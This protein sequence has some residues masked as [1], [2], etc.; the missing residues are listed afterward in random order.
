MMRKHDEPPMPGIEWCEGCDTPGFYREVTYGSTC[1][2][3]AVR[4]IGRELLSAST[5]Y[6][7]DYP[8]AI[9]GYVHEGFAEMRW[10]DKTWELAP[11]TA[12]W[13]R[14]RQEG[15]RVRMPGFVPVHDIVM[16]Y[17]AGSADLFA[18]I[19]SPAGAVRLKRPHLVTS[20]FAEM[21]NEIRYGTSWLEHNAL[22]L[23]RL[24]A[25]RL[26][27]EVNAAR[28]QRSQSRSTFDRCRQYVLSNFIRIQRLSDVSEACGVSS[29]HMCRLFEQFG[30]IPPYRLVIRERLAK[31]ARLLET[32]D[33][34]IRDIAAATGF[35]D[36]S[37]FS[38]LFSKQYGV[39]P[40]VYGRRRV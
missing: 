25:A 14:E 5:R 35:T 18:K 33:Q 11:G 8:F 17:G 37:R 26:A 20:L 7:Y 1:D 19:G 28:E 34:P 3:L 40:S 13:I 22:L 23:T 29:E 6:G 15:Y 24:L 27:V 30:E 38:R 32:T 16:V 39:P 12:F 9:I 10:N 2:G 31:S 36:Q 21:A 4:W